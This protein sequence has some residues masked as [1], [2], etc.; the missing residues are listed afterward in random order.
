MAAAAAEIVRHSATWYDL[1]R[2]SDGEEIANARRFYKADGSPFSGWIVRSL[3][4]G[5]YSDPIPT[6]RAALA[7]LAKCP[8]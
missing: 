1:I 8:V 6:K 3:I 5:S 2:A 4:D 7:E